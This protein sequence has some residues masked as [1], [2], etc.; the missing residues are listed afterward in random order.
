[1]KTLIRVLLAL[2]SAAGVLYWLLSLCGRPFC[3]L[4]RRTFGK[5]ARDE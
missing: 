4:W 3:A 2:A 1:M 5:N